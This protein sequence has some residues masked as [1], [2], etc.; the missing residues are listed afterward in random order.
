[1]DN[2]EIDDTTIVT[3]LYSKIRSRERTY[4]GMKDTNRRV[5]RRS[6][7][8]PLRQAPLLICIPHISAVLTP[9]LL[10]GACYA[11]FKR[12]SYHQR[13][14]LLEPI[15]PDSAFPGC[16]RRCQRIHPLDRVLYPGLRRPLYSKRNRVKSCIQAFLFYPP[17]AFITK[18]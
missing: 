7:I 14:P 15:R 16:F 10:K 6:P 9:P 8:R 12:T 18:C 5:Q 2:P 11:P 17:R 4:T 1:M 13:L 3:Q